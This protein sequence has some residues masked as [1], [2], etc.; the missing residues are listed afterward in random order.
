MAREQTSI[1]VALPENL[2]AEKYA[3]GAILTNRDAWAKVAAILEAADFS[4]EKHKRIFLRMRDLAER[5]EP[6]DRV[7][8]ANE[9]QGHGQLEAVGIGYLVSLDEGMPALANLEAYAQIVK[10][11]S[12]LRAIVRLS[13]DAM[14]RAIEQREEAAEISAQAS[15]RLLDLAEGSMRAALEPS[16]EIVDRSALCILDPAQHST[17]LKT[18]FTKFDD[19]TGGLREGELCILGARPAMGKTAFA[20]NTAAH[21]ALHPKNPKAVAIFSLE[22]TKESLLQRMMCGAARVDQ[23]RQRLGYTNSEEKRAL[24]EALTALREAPLYLDDSRN[25]TLMDVEAKL[26][27]LKQDGADLGLVVIDYLQLMKGRGKF[28]N[29]VQEIGSIS[30]GLKV[31]AGELRVPILALSQLSRACE[32]RPGDHRPVLSDLRDSGDVEQDADLVAFIFREEVYKPDKESLRGLAELILAKQRN[33]PIGKIKLAFLHK[34]TKFENLAD[35]SEEQI[36]ENEQQGWSPSGKGL[37]TPQE[38]EQ[39]DDDLPAY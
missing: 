2:D 3:L 29:R 1:D 33:G 10:E 26:L 4:L 38:Q 23:L 22:M 36:S 31:M 5:G 24:N 34:Y 35:D 30:R 27:R 21:V 20:L 32:T 9:L 14:A 15:R 25:V 13:Q 8:V 6:I 12:R 28:D 16:S 39:G 18:G 19:K 17:G 7:T 11:K 37:F